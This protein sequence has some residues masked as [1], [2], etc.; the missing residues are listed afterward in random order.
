MISLKQIRLTENEIFNYLQNNEDI[1]IPSLS[2]RV[3]LRKFSLKLS[4][5]AVHFCAFDNDLLIGL[6][7]CY[8][9]DLVTL[10][11]F[12]STASVVKEYQGQGIASA[13]LD[14][15]VE[16]GKSKG[17]TRIMLEVRNENEPAIKIYR[18]CGFIRISTT[19]NV[20]A[21]ELKL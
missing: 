2:S 19:G 10:T 14:A 4:E 20:T 16:Y 8:F 18:E 21:M 7:A 17:F 3:D 9:N 1:F 5:R 11:G 6:I 15:A 12:I 13:L